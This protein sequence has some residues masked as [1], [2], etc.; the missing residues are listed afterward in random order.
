MSQAIALTK[1]VSRNQYQ[2][3]RAYY[4]LGRAR[5]NYGQKDEGVQNLKIAA[6]LREKSCHNRRR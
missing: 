5:M 3:S 4:V 1:D 2:I 6:D